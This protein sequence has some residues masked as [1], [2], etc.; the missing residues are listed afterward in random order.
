[1]STFKTGFLESHDGMGCIYSLTPAQSLNDF[2]VSILELGK[3][4]EP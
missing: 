3:P 1:M 2:R 4:Q